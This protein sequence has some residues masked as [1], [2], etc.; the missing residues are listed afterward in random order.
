VTD[1]TEYGGSVSQSGGVIVVT[2]LTAAASSGNA[3]TLDSDD[4]IPVTLAVD[5]QAS[6][7]SAISGVSKVPY[8]LGDSTYTVAGASSSTSNE[9]FLDAG[10]EIKVGNGG[11]TDDE[12][13]DPDIDREVVTLL[14]NLQATDTFTISSSVPSA[15]VFTSAPASTAAFNTILGFEVPAISL[16]E[17][18][19]LTGPAAIPT[20]TALTIVATKTLTIDTGV[21]LTLDGAGSIVLT[22]A[23][24]NPAK[25]VFAGSGA[26]LI[27]GGNG[28]TELAAAAGVFAD[29]G[30][31]QD[32]MLVSAFAELTITGGDNVLTSIVYTSGS[33]PYISGPANN[34]GSGGTLSATT[35]CQ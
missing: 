15:V 32:I 4:P 16:A 14:Q 20:A 19:T 17:D 18:F 10:Y 5:A 7:V 8:V 21:I 25:I 28:V 3:T 29:S 35:D 30:T 6:Q 33:N 27:T 1:Y 24:S 11:G 23:A 26:T 12:T 13:L 2:G 34:S 31:A 9:V 22:N